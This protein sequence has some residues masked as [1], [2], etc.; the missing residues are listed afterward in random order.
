MAWRDGDVNM[1]NVEGGRSESSGIIDGRSAGG[2]R[3]ITHGSAMLLRNDE[4][5]CDGKSGSICGVNKRVA[6]IERGQGEAVEGRLPPDMR[7]KKGG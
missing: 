5:P 1:R 3:A 4:K 6:D 7:G 2:I